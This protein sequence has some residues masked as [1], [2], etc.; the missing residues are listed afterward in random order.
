MKNFRWN[1]WWKELLFFGGTQFLGLAVAKRYLLATVLPVPLAAVK[2]S[3][4]DFLVTA[5]L[6]SLLIWGGMRRQ[7][8][9][10]IV[11]RT[12][13][14]LVILGGTQVI[15]S[16]FFSPLLSLV[17]SI[18]LL[19]LLFNLP[20]I[21]LQNLVILITLAGV[22]LM[23]GLSLTPLLAVWALVVLSFYD[24]LA[25]YVTKHMV[26]MAEGMISAGVIFGFIIPFETNGFWESSKEV[27]PGEK[28]MI[29]G[30]G[31]IALPLIL[32]ASVAR[33]SFTQAWVVA[34]FSLLGLT[35]T[36]LLFV[37]QKQ[38]RPMAALPPIALLSVVGYLVAAL[39]F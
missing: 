2:F 16:A 25:V 9:G 28:F 20:R 17:T 38:R 8:F 4:T 34:A 22:S 21:L 15:F 13:F 5:I 18:L 1:L 30:S 33:T 35:L 31:D 6:L 11:Y 10:K 39:I 7:R 3:W 36:H 12:F 37:S 26:R 14:V 23:I 24:I 27:K 29:L 19:L 32:A